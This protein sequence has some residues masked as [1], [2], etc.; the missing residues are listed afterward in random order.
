[1]AK[2]PIKT[3]F[4]FAANN[5]EKTQEEY[6]HLLEDTAFTYL[7]YRLY[8]TKLEDNYIKIQDTIQNLSKHQIEDIQEL[9]QAMKQSKGETIQLMDKTSMLLHKKYTRQTKEN[10]LAA[11]EIKD[12]INHEQVTMINK[13]KETKQQIFDILTKI[14]QN[15]ITPPR[16]TQTTP[17]PTNT[18]PTTTQ[19]NYHTSYQKTSSPK[20]AKY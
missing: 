6:E 15:N 2:I 20:N 11:N 7:K 16:Q 9:E 14:N 19:K 18:D 10:L 5:I 8:T 17:Q 1:M 4:Q 12:H 13:Y 3:D